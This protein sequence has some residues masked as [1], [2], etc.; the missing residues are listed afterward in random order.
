MSKEN[1]SGENRFPIG[2]DGQ[3]RYSDARGVVESIQFRFD[4]GAAYVEVELADETIAVMTRDGI[5]VDSRS[6]LRSHR[7]HQVR[8]ADRPRCGPRLGR[9]GLTLPDH[10]TI[11]WSDIPHRP[12]LAASHTR[13][14]CH[15]DVII[16]LRI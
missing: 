1:A 13:F 5:E 14:P 16:R 15:H 2:P 6:D 8:R 9:R 12:N 3:P 11:L 10:S 4:D 7:R